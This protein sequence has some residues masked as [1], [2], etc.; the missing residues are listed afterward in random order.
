MDVVLD[1]ALDRR[2][3]L[4]GITTI[5]KQAKLSDDADEITDKIF[6]LDLNKTGAIEH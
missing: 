1:G 6:M 2:E 4:D 5:L 3:A